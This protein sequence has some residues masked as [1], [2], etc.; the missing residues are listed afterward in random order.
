[1]KDLAIAYSVQRQMKRGLPKMEE[2]VTERENPMSI[3]EAIRAKK[4]ATKAEP[5]ESM[6]DDI[7]DLDLEDDEPVEAPP[8]SPLKA[9]LADI[10]KARGA[11]V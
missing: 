8:G 2:S 10:M 5:V 3:V 6:D 7:M 1:M 11:K 9:R 4:L